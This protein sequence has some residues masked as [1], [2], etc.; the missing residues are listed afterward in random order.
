MF[1]VLLLSAVITS[2]DPA[3]LLDAVKTCDA[4][5][6]HTLTQ[7]E[8]HRRAEFAAAIYGEQRAIADDRQRVLATT[9]SGSPAGQ[10]TVTQALAQLDARQKELDDDRAI[11]RGWRDLLDEARADYLA[12]CTN[13]QRDGK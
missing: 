9:A 6:L 13:K 4:K 8:A 3:P 7:G 12:N 5:D 2:P 11:E 10:A 1:P